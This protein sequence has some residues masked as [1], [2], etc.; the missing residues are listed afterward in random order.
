MQQGEEYDDN[1]IMMGGGGA[2]SDKSEMV[3]KEDVVMMCRDGTVGGMMQQGN[4][5]D[6]NGIMICGDGA[7]CDMMQHIGDD[8]VFADSEQVIKSDDRDCEGVVDSKSVDTNIS[9]RSSRK[10]RTNVRG[11]D[12]EPSRTT[13]VRGTCLLTNVRGTDG[14]GGVGDAV[15]GT[16]WSGVTGSSNVRGP[17]DEMILRYKSRR[18]SSSTSRRS[19][20]TIST[21][22]LM[23]TRRSSTGR[24][25][26]SI[27]TT[28]GRGLLQSR[29]VRL[30]ASGFLS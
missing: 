29:G 19:S 9:M 14:P 30:L 22:P 11:T 12:V 2:K 13:N 25:T 26:R 15:L 18:S 8:D 24:V 23:G 17:L 5:N 20:R 28:G 1:A 7:T 4:E 16:V 27:R 10:S 6:D 3:Q 21:P